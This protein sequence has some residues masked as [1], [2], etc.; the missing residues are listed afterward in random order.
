[1]KRALIVWVLASACGAP[2]QQ[3][4]ATLV[5]KKDDV[6]ACKNLR[7]VDDVQ[8]KYASRSR[9]ENRP[10]TDEE[11]A[12]LE[13]MTACMKTLVDADRTPDRAT[14]ATET[15]VAECDEAIALYE[16]V[17]ECDKFKEMPADEIKAQRDV[18]QAM[19]DG[20]QPLRDA[21]IEAKRAAADGCR[22]AIDGLREAAKAMGCSL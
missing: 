11:K 16:R 3:Q 8:K 21:P 14:R 5:A 13:Q 22:Q 2:A 4:P 10:V 7:C 15:G 17:F 18:L 19:K 6:C 20:W 1:M 9:D 12:A